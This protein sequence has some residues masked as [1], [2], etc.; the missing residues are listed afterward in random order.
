VI[1]DSLFVDISFV[2]NPNNN[3]LIS[4]TTDYTSVENENLVMYSNKFEQIC[5]VNSVI[6][7][8][9]YNNT[10]E[11]NFVICDLNFVDISSIG[12]GGAISITSSNDFDTYSVINCYFKSCEVSNGKGGAI[13][14]DGAIVV[15]NS[16]EFY[17]NKA[18]DGNDV[19]IN[20]AHGIFFYSMK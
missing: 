2:T 15:L 19:F 17:L 18:D 10:E 9:Y 14:S 3:S 4:I 12:S 8:H 5:G 7:I 1:K 16:T 11:G 6:N 13:Y 20:H